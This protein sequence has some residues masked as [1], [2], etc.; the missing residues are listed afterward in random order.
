MELV[1]YYIGL[2]WYEFN[3]WYSEWCYWDYE[4]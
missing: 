1:I 2:L 4:L 3:I